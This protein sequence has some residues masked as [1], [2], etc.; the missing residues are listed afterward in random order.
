MSEEFMFLESGELTA[1]VTSQMQKLSF[2]DVTKEFLVTISDKRCNSP[3][4]DI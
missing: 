4:V 1:T 2:Y 3:V